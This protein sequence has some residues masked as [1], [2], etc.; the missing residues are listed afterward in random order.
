MG[1]TGVGDSSAEAVVVGRQA[2]RARRVAA[3][4]R[5][6]NSVAEAEV[7]EAS[8]ERVEGRSRGP[9]VRRSARSA[10]RVRRG[11]RRP[12]RAAI[13]AAA[14]RA[15]NSRRRED[16]ALRVAQSSRRVAIGEQRWT[17]PSCRRLQ[18]GTSVAF[19]LAGITHAVISCTRTN[20]ERAP[21]N[22]NA[23]PGG[24]TRDEDP[25]RRGP[26]P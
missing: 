4:G 15:A 24:E 5:Y 10:I 25:P 7:R 11:E 3:T 26:A 23:S 18:R 20:S 21:A 19:A 22:T 12:A 13:R 8:F 17:A 16:T 14:A 9:R 2:P 6:E 1:S